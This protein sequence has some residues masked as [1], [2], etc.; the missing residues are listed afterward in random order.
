MLAV[1]ASER[2]RLRATFD[3]AAGLYQEARPDYP[4]ALYAE[5]ARAAGTRPGDRL[6]EIGC[7]TGKATLPLARRGLAITGLEPGPELAAA[8]RRNLAAFPAVRVVPTDFETW[9]AAPGETFDLVFAATAWHWIDPAAGFARAWE[10]LVPGGHLAI[11]HQGHVFP[12]GGDP[13]FTQ[14][15]PVYDEIGAGAPPGQGRPRPGELPDGLSPAIEASGL[16]DISSVAQF[17]W[18]VRYDAEGYLRLLDTFSNH[19]AM[20]P[21]QRDRLYGE[22]RRRL[23]RRPD[24]QLRRHWGAIL[25]VARR[26][27]LPPRRAPTQR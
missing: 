23:A 19:I 7:A 9:A 13:I 20:A 1:E 16:F 25:H 26:R 22:I 24:G 14:L 11:W 18:E 15:Q 27:D 21:W 5:L 8:A 3:A 17:D 2:D 10:L 6:L 4:D 12:D